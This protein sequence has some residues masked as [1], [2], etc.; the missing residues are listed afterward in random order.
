MH[1]IHFYTLRLEHLKTFVFCSALFYDIYLW[2]Q[3]HFWAA[4]E[5]DQH[6]AMATT[7]TLTK[8]C[9]KLRH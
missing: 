4:L 5:R 8:L 3:L 9:S 6:C 7:Q 1:Y 2:L